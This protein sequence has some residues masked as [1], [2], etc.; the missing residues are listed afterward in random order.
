[1]FAL[2]AGSEG[3]MICKKTLRYRFCQNLGLSSSCCFGDY[4]MCHVVENN[5]ISRS[6]ESEHDHNV[7]LPMD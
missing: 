2:K 7:S 4:E 5:T 3:M 6:L 1:M